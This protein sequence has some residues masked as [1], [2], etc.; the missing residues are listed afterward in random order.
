MIRASSRR[1]RQI[2][3]EEGAGKHLEDEQNITTRAKTEEKKTSKNII[4][5]EVKNR[6]SR[7]DQRQG[8]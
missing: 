2:H 6:T 8:E 5:K 3:E 4:T 7:G 1:S